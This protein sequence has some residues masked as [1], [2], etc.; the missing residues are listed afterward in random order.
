MLEAKDSIL[1]REKVCDLDFCAGNWLSP[2]IDFLF[3]DHGFQGARIVFRQTETH[4]STPLHEE[5]VDRGALLSID[6][7]DLLQESRFISL[8]FVDS[9]L[10]ADGEDALLP[11][12]ILIE[13]TLIGRLLLVLPTGFLDVELAPLLPHLHHTY[14]LTLSYLAILSGA[15]DLG[16]HGGIGHA[17]VTQ[18]EQ[19]V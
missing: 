7:S 5:L 9:L 4:P 15:F 16:D 17:K 8:K 19:V 1:L 6:V 11:G 18:G 10:Q 2:L 13:Q 14:H 3:L 12:A